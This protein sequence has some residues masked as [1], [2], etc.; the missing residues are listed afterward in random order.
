MRLALFPA[1]IGEEEESSM[2]LKEK[3]IQDI[4]LKTYHERGHY[5]ITLNFVGMGLGECDVISISSANFSYEFEIKVSR[6]D[7]K[8]DFKNKWGK[9]DR[10]SGNPGIRTYD[11]STPKGKIKDY[12]KMYESC[13]YFFYVC[14][15]GLISA[16]EVP[17][18]AGL[19]YVVE[20]RREMELKEIKKAPLLHKE[21]AD[22][23]L[24]KQIGR[25]LTNKLFFGCSYTEYKFKSKY[26]E[27]LEGEVVQ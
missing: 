25:N 27:K 6:S 24:I 12:Y 3:E 18:Y 15:D 4:I 22:A 23:A 26:A 14:P 11:K 7:F 1:W 8:A 2:N 21:K 5:P 13:N 10:M 19:I 9:H 17:E 16:E 20:G